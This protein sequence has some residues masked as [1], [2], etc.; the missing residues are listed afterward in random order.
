MSRILILA[1]IGLG[2]TLLLRGRVQALPWA[3]AWAE[4][5]RR[6]PVPILRSPERR[7]RV[8]RGAA[9]AQ[10]R[11]RAVTLERIEL[12]TQSPVV[13]LAERGNVLYA[14]T[15]DE[16]LIRIEGG[17]QR[18]LPVDARINDLALDA[19]GALIVATGGGA[20]EVTATGAATKFAS[21]AFSAVASWRGETWLVSRRGLSVRERSGLWTRGAGQGVGADLPD[22]L[23]S[24]GSSLC[25]GASDG[26]WLFD[27]QSASRHSSA[28]GDLPA[29]WVTAA[30]GDEKEVWAGTF[31]GGLARLGGSKDPGRLYSS[32]GGLPE[33]QIAPHALAVVAGVVYAG[34][35]R[36][37]LV[38]EGQAAQLFGDGPL[39]EGVSAVIPAA[40]GGV[41]VGGLGQVRRIVV[42]P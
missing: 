15:F 18:A 34:T 17:A 31:D 35:P 38:V 32:K 1:L 6:L 42:T 23:A 13:A 25:I 10:G 28:S 9:L 39:G 36:G 30:W 3:R 5:V 24:C 29:D 33:G 12:G 26:L 7:S 2:T 37:L 41:W 19:S 16:G 21:G 27:G 11:L 22:A 8:E 40:R 20:F 4:R 14:G